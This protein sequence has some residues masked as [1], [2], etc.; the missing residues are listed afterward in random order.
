M[1]ILKITLFCNIGTK[2]TF[3]NEG[4]ESPGVIPADIVFTL[5]TKPHDRFE[6]DGDDLI[7]YATISLQEALCGVKLS[8]LTLDGRTIHVEMHHVNPDTVKILPG[9]GMVNAKVTTHLK[10]PYLRQ[11][12]ENC[13]SEKVKGG[14]ADKV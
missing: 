7:Y 11:L 4:D 12:M 1:G 6:R 2:I 10:Y 13:T 8:V 14:Y 9:E 5:Q 3:E